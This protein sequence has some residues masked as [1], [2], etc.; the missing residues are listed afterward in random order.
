MTLTWIP[1]STPGAPAFAAW[2]GSI[3]ALVRPMG[4]GRWRVGGFPDGRSEH[5]H[6]AYV[7]G[8]ARARSF[9]ERWVQHHGTSVRTK[10][11]EP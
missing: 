8:E 1:P 9:V 5:S 10:T 7:G 11:P 6:D 4:D 3:F 2:N